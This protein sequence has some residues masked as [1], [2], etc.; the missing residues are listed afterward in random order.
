MLLRGEPATGC[1]TRKAKVASFQGMWEQNAEAQFIG[2]L[3]REFSRKIRSSPVTHTQK[4][5]H[6]LLQQHTGLELMQRMMLTF[7]FP[8]KWITSRRTEENPCFLLAVSLKGKHKA[9]LGSNV[10]CRG[11]YRG[12]ST[13]AGKSK[14]WNGAAQSTPGVLCPRARGLLK[15]EVQESPGS[16]LH[17]CS[18]H[19]FLQ[20]TSATAC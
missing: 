16:S 14:V 5:T 3:K 18:L 19:Q 6:P 4:S 8:Q 9:S 10:L 1:M 13:L 12:L 11:K 2:C 17:F 20:N 7:L 15:G